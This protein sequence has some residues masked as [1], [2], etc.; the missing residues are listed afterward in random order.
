MQARFNII[1]FDFKK[2]KITIFLKARLTLNPV[3][4]IRS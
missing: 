3:P 1:Q 2:F 4:T